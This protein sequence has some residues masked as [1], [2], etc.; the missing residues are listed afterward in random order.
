MPMPAGVDATHEMPAAGGGRDDAANRTEDATIDGYGVTEAPADATPGPSLSL[1]RDSSGVMAV[2]T[3]ALLLFAASRY[4]RE[5]QLS[6]LPAQGTLVAG[7]VLL[8]EAQAAMWIAPLWRLSWWG[9]HVLMLAGFLVALAGFGL[10]YARRRS[11]SGLV[12][13]LFLTDTI[14]RIE[15]S[16]SE[17]IFA[18]VAA[19]EA[20]DR[21]TKGHSA[22]VSQMA[23]LIGEALRLGGAELR[24]LGRGGLVHDVGK[25]AV[26]DA[27]LSK[28]GRLT[29][30]EYEVV[31]R[32]VNGYDVI[33]RVVSLR[34]ELP[35]VLYHHEWY[36][37]RGYPQG[38]AGERIPLAARIT[39]VADVYD[40]LTSER[41]Y[42]PPMTEDEAVVHL[43]KMAGTQFDPKVV[44]AFARIEPQWRERRRRLGF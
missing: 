10:S 33:K 18:L 11:L 37:G 9:Y 13:T 17:V 7:L 16:Y 19:V 15:S 6:A 5:Y 42:R 24:S 4:R 21:Y 44:E 28:P 29:P 23:V 27:I 22:R 30:E 14:D 26:P 36:D 35:I 25:L 41:P 43:R 20:R 8:A 38:L 3:I 34:D 31:K 2:A 39:A 12:E 32:P 1:L 40:A